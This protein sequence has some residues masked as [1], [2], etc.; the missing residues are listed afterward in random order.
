MKQECVAAEYACGGLSSLY[1]GGKGNLG[2]HSRREKN[3]LMSRDTVS[4]RSCGED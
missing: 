2:S 1:T 4:T 3:I